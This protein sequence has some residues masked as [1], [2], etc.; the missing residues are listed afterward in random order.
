MHCMSHC[1]AVGVYMCEGEKNLSSHFSVERSNVNVFHL[2]K[3]DYMEN[4]CS[5]R[6]CE[7]QSGML[8][9]GLCSY[10]KSKDLF[11]PYL[12]QKQCFVD[13]RTN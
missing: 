2:L 10:W 11:L 13:L 4:M 1:V 3:V 9:V 6:G 5:F 12:T 8:H 7:S